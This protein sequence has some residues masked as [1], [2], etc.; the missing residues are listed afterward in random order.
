MKLFLSLTLRDLADVRE[1][2]SHWLR[3]IFGTDLVIMESFSSA[4][5]VCEKVKA[6]ARGLLCYWVL[7]E[8][9]MSN[10]EIGKN[11]ISASQLLDTQ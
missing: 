5:W 7:R 9:M 3:E 4:S 2:I 1:K 10:R 8:L 11:S 6:R